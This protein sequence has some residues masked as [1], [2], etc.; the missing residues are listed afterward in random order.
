MLPES[1]CWHSDHSLEADEHLNF[2][3]SLAQPFSDWC[4]DVINLVL[5]L[6]R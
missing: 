2:T 1:L 3:D 4:V 5:S 6:F